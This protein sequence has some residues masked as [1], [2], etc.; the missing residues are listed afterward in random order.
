MII[1]VIKKI[2]WL[3]ENINCNDGER[4]ILN[5]NM[6]DL[7]KLE[8]RLS[9]SSFDTIECSTFYY[10]FHHESKVKTHLL[11]FGCFMEIGFSFLQSM[12]NISILKVHV[13]DKYHVH[14]LRCGFNCQCPTYWCGGSFHRKQDAIA[15][16]TEN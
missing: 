3:N 7:L 11:C 1:P 14:C 10:F 16:C 6:E 13:H 12:K 15:F 9:C 2:I 5:F 8:K 4:F